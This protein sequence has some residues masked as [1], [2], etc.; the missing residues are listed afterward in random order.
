MLNEH[1]EI[2]SVLKLNIKVIKINQSA[3]D[4]TDKSYKAHYGLKKF[5]RFLLFRDGK[6]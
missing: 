3:V 6:C 2:H 4:A 1:C 5:K